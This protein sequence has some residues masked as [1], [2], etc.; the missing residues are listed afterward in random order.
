MTDED[1]K[2]TLKDIFNDRMNNSEY[3]DKL[4]L[5]RQ[6]Q[7]VDYFLYG[8]AFIRLRPDSK[9]PFPQPPL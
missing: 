1:I 5:E 3:W 8:D 2:S 6:T 9:D 4:T 7:W